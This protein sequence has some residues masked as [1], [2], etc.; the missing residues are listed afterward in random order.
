MY[1]S[2][3]SLL[4]TTILLILMISFFLPLFVVLMFIILIYAGISYLYSVI[5]GKPSNINIKVVRRTYKPDS[6]NKDTYI[7]SDDDYID[8]TTADKDEK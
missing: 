2:P 8:S 5:T 3:L 6:K 7:N 4:A 1:Y